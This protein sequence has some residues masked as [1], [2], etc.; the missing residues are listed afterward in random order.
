MDRPAAVRRSGP[1]RDVQ[2]GPQPRPD[3]RAAVLPGDLGPQR[4]PPRHRLVRRARPARGRAPR[5]D[6]GRGRAVVDGPGAA[7]RDRLVLAADEPGPG[8]PRGARRGRHPRP[9]PACRQPAL[10]R[11]RRAALPG[12]ACWPIDATST[13]SSSTSSCP[14][15][16]PTACSAPRATGRCGS[17]I[18]PVVAEP[19]DPPWRSRAMLRRE[20]VELGELV[21]VEIDGI[22]GERYVL[23]AEVGLLDVAEA[24]LAAGRG[25]GGHEPA[26]A[27]LAPLDPLAWDRA[28][29]RSLYRLRLRLGGVRPRGEATLGLLRPADPVRRPAG[30]PDRAADR[31]RRGRPADPR[32]V[33]GGRLRAAGRAGI[34]GS[35]GR[36]HIE[37][38][39]GSGRPAGSSCPDPTRI[40]RSSPPCASGSADPVPP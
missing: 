37:S 38:I 40:G 1:V 3:R 17:G 33:V 2:Q 7:G 15:T 14:G 35:P 10:L 18:G 8:A 11:P 4:D 6:P 34:R 32:A 22:S 36:G 28:L 31:S 12:R 26:A 23:S 20:L 9:E 16:G 30:R 21:P 27:F 13:I 24:E 39:A 19:G 5:A 25:P 29:L